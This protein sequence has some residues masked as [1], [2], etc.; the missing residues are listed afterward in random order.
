M[1]YFD[2]KTFDEVQKFGKESVDASM[3][4]FSTLSKGVQ[5]IAV[6]SVEA[7]GSVFTVSLPLGLQEAG[8]A[9]G[10]VKH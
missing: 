8:T 9:A 6:E 7:Q 4:T 2:T 3:N 1:N 5:A 10:A